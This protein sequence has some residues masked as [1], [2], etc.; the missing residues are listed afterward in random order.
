MSAFSVDWLDLREDAD[1]RARDSNLLTQARQWLSANEI[2]TEAP[3]VVDLG[4]GTAA[5]LRAFSHPN[6]LNSSALQPNSVALSWRLVDHDARL[7][8]EAQ[9]RHAKLE[10]LETCLTDLANIDTLPLHDARLVTASA[11]FDL[12]SAGFVHK[13]LARLNA[14]G[15][16]RPIGLYA[17][18]NYDGSTH[19]TPAHPYDAL[20][21]A[22]FNRDQGKDKGFGPALGP[23]ATSCLQQG[24]L[25]TSGFRVHT[26]SSPWLLDG[27]DHRLQKALIAGI[28]AAVA[29]DLSTNAIA[30]DD[31]RRFRLA[32][33]ASGTCRVGHTDLLAL[34]IA[35]D[36]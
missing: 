14:Q 2:Q 22:A 17:A 3:L 32:H 31:W 6:L 9:H 20:V 28:A 19:W 36:N 29:E 23:A 35:D 15:Q 11:L 21:L 1:R 25:E 13:L 24:F 34:P 27:N 7:L 26:A 12:V 10:N 5:T 18:L 4:S 8:A 33:I 16:N 30:L